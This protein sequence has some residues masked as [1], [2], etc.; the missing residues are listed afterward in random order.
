MALTWWCLQRARFGPTTV[1]SV[2][3]S[4]SLLTPRSQS[5]S[6]RLRRS[7]TCVSLYAMLCSASALIVRFWSQKLLADDNL[8]NVPFLVL[9]NKIDKPEAVSEGDM[10]AQ[11]GLLHHTTGKDVRMLIRARFLAPRPSSLTPPCVL[12]Q[13]AGTE[14]RGRAPPHRVVHVQHH[15]EDGLCRGFQMAWCPH[16]RAQMWKCGRCQCGVFGRDSS[17]SSLGG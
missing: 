13:L 12:W 9:G 2:T 10:L 16:L 1:P 14:G 8:T 3:A 6:Q 7:S 4:F 17:E 11:L 15:A 5:V